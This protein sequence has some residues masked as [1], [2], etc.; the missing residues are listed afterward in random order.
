MKKNMKKQRA[1]GAD[2]TRPGAQTT[3]KTGAAASDNDQ[4]SLFGELTDEEKALIPLNTIRTE[5]VLSKLPLH[6]LTRD[7]RRKS[8]SGKAKDRQPLKAISVVEKDERGVVK[9]SWEV[10]FNSKFGPPGSGE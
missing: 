3:R 7:D 10:S 9:L 2:G 5:T 8:P 4:I 1:P 6:V